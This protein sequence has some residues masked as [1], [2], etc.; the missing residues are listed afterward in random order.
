MPESGSSL[1]IYIFSW[2]FLIFLSASTWHIWRYI[3]K[4]QTHSEINQKVIFITLAALVGLMIGVWLNVFLV[5]VLDAI[6]I[7]LL[8]LKDLLGHLRT[9]LQHPL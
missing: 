5:I 1:V 9:A 6:G 7:Y 2:L 4:S 3:T 8:D